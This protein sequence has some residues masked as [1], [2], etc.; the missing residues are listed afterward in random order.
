MDPRSTARPAPQ[1]WEEMRR[2]QSEMERVFGAATPAWR[3]PLTGEY[4]PINLTRGADGITV[5]SACPGADRETLEVTVIGEAVTIRGER[6][7]DPQL[8]SARCHRRERPMGTFTRTLGLGERLDPDKAQATY[9]HGILRVRLA[10]MPEAAPK[11]IDIQ[12]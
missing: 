11:K 4:P 2:L 5:E 8:E 12:G 9:K 10:R 1:P 3:W 6:K 7:P